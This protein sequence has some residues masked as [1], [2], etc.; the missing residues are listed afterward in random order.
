MLKRAAVI[1]PS[2]LQNYI[3]EEKLI[4]KY[5]RYVSSIEY[6]KKQPGRKTIGRCLGRIKAFKFSWELIDLNL[7]DYMLNTDR[8]SA[9][10]TLNLY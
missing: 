10:K 6:L 8:V 2:I 5:K 4:E 9:I 1:H 7:E 3:L